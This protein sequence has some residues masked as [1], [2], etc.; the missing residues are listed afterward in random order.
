[1]A[2]AGAAI[3]GQRMRCPLLQCIPN[4]L[5]NRL[6][7]L[8]QVGI[9]TP[10]HSDTAR[11]QPGVPLSIHSLLVWVS[12]P[13]TVQF[14]VQLCFQ[15]EEVQDIRPVRMLPPEFVAGKAAVTQPTP[16]QPLCPS[17]VLTQR[18]SDGCLFA[19]LHE[20]CLGVRLSAG[21][22]GRFVPP[23]PYPLP[24]GEGTGQG[25]LRAFRP[26]SIRR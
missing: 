1:M 26:C 18:A 19:R 21:Q 23:H 3:V 12:V 11:L 8:P 14:D 15:A 20:G 4:A 24:Q 25:A 6:L 16:D 10:Q 7:L 9:P 5:A 2:K 13:R 22:F 17:I